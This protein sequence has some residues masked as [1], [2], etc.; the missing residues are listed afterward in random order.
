MSNLTSIYAAVRFTLEPEGKHIWQ[1]CV[2]A[3]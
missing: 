1:S 3:C 2:L